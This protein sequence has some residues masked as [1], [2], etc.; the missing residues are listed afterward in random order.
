M[1]KIYLW[2]YIKK[3]NGKY[4]AMI[5]RRDP[6][7]FLSLES[8]YWIIPGA[9]F[10]TSEEALSHGRRLVNRYNDPRRKGRL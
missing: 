6:K 8:K 5:S 9:E 2:G 3:T 10:L 4:T 1:K 7:K